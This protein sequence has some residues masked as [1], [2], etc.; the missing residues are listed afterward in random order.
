[1]MVKARILITTMPMMVVVGRRAWGGSGFP[2][3]RA[4]SIEVDV[5]AAGEEK[6]EEEEERVWM[7]VVMVR[8]RVLVGRGVGEESAAGAMAVELTSGIAD[9]VAGCKVEAIVTVS[10]MLFGVAK[11]IG[12]SAGGPCS[13]TG[14]LSCIPDPGIV[15]PSGQSDG[16]AIQ[17]GSG[18]F[19]PFKITGE[20]TELGCKMI[21]EGSE[22]NAPMRLVVYT[23]E[24][25]YT[26]SDAMSSILHFLAVTESVRSGRG[27]ICR[28]RRGED[29]AIELCLILA[30]QW[31]VG[32]K[33]K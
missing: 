7:W 20:G 18:S 10:C 16:P 24:D 2:C 3:I 33:G 9:C 32:N 1:M 4:S 13:R 8:M 26:F 11:G 30:T 29:N 21:A 31:H 23:A 27:G 17:E 28:T 22:R 5:F 12:A 6:E 14:P 19:I 15:E 25:V